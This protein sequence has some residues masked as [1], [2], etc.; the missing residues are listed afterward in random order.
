MKTTDEIK[1]EAIEHT[2]A[3]GVMKIEHHRDGYTLDGLGFTDDGRIVARY[4]Q[5]HYC[6]RSSAAAEFMYLV[7]QVGGGTKWTLVK[8]TPYNPVKRLRSTLPCGCGCGKAESSVD[9]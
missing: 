1:A 5:R 8:W 2:T 3:R 4:Y 9:H 6:G 7:E